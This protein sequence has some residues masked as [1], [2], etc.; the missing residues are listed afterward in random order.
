MTPEVNC[1]KLSVKA[2]FGPYKS[3]VND[4]YLFPDALTLSQA[5]KAAKRL[6]KSV[7]IKFK[8]PL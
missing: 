3:L 7:I 1:C 8:L 4:F 5:F 2:S 6:C